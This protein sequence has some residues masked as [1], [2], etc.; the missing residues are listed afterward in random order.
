MNTGLMSYQIPLIRVFGLAKTTSPYFLGLVMFIVGEFVLTKM[1]IAFEAPLALVAFI[2]PLTVAGQ[3]SP[4][5]KL[6]NFKKLFVGKNFATTLARI[7]FVR[8]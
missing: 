5:A 3:V 2:R 1:C 8:V 7:G 6:V 4:H